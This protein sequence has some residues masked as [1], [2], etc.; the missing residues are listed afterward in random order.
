MTD[1]FVTEK[2]LALREENLTFKIIDRFS[3]LL[4]TK[5][6]ALEVRIDESNITRRDQVV[7]EITGFPYKDR[8]KI[9]KGIQHSYSDAVK[10]EDTKQKI[11]TTI[12][13]WG[14][15]ASIVATITWLMK[16]LPGGS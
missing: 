2:E 6:N 10:S 7:E 15:P 4:D 8:A 5:F 16:H 3:E 1:E 12:I 9:K 11:K 13:V 14:L